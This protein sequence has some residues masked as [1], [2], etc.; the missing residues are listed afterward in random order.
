VA[1]RY[2]YLDTPLP[3]PFAHRGGAADGDENSLEAFGRAIGSGY[4]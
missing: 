1:H 2:P 4:R 3:I